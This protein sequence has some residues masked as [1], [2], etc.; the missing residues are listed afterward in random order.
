MLRGFI[1]IQFFF[2]LPKVYGDRLCFS[3]RIYLSFLQ[4]NLS[5]SSVYTV[6]TQ[7]VYDGLIPQNQFARQMLNKIYNNK[8]QEHMTYHH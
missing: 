6:Y 1:F 7:S 3:P 2:D 8:T 4:V 5:A